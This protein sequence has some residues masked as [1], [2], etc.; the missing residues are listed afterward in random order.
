MLDRCEYPDEE[1]HWIFGYGDYLK[2]LAY[3]LRKVGVDR[4]DVTNKTPL[5]S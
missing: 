3:A 5:K 4:L 1:F 2:E